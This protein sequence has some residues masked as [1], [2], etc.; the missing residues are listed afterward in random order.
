M[1]LR[2]AAESAA[3][4]SRHAAAYGYLPASV[5]AFA[6]PD[7]FVK[8]LRQAGFSEISAVPLTFGSVILYTARRGQDRGPA[9][10][11]G[12]NLVNCQNS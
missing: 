2:A 12:Q 1:Q 6:T 4:V 3:L 7:E 9:W 5:G 11:T 8:I 10:W